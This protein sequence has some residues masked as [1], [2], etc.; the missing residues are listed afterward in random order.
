MGRRMR[1]SLRR[2]IEPLELIS[3][4]SEQSLPATLAIIKSAFPDE[5]E[6]VHVQKALS[7]RLNLSTDWDETDPQIPLAVHRYM[8]YKSKQ[9]YYT[10]WLSSTETLE[11]ILTGYAD[12]SIRIALGN[13]SSDYVWYGRKSALANIAEF[14][15]AGGKRIGALYLSN[16]EAPVYMSHYEKAD[17]EYNLSQLPLTDT[18]IVISTHGSTKGMPQP[19]LISEDAYLNDI[20]VNWAYGIQTVEDRRQEKKGVYE[21]YHGGKVCWPNRSLKERYAAVSYGEI[22]QRDVGLR[23][24]K[25]GLIIGGNVLGFL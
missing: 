5:N 1:I 4:F 18:T 16:I 12:G 25:P 2:S 24:I 15:Q 23:E 14:L 10:S 7:T 13:F 3:C 20:S 8:E 22:P 21:G 11:K 6:W 17:L 9:P 19:Q